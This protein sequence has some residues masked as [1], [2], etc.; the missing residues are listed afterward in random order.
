MYV[1]RSWQVASNYPIEP[2]T[3]PI[4]KNSAGVSGGSYV[5][6][7]GTPP[8]RAVVR[9]L[10]K[11]DRQLWHRGKSQSL[12]MPKDLHITHICFYAT[13]PG[14]AHLAHR[15]LELHNFNLDDDALIPCE[16]EGSSFAAQS[17][18]ITWK[19]DY[20]MEQ[21]TVGQQQLQ[22]APPPMRAL[23]VASNVEARYARQL[24]SAA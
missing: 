15:G 4:E 11:S 20:A 12:Y 8:L 2:T 10:A 18:S 24:A 9:C 13:H 7:D 1:A 5:S 17:A 19:L 21:K 22:R 23:V 3:G 16:L 6:L 14:L